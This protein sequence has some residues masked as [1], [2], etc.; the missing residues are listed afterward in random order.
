MKVLSWNIRG[1]LKETAWDH[2]TILLKEHNPDLILLVETHLN[3]EN[4]LLCIN[5]FGHNWSGLFVAAE[6]RSGGIVFVWKKLYYE[7][8]LLFSCDQLMNILIQPLNK[9]PW[10]L[11]GIYASNIPKERSILWKF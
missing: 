4:S 1:G 10:L 5:K 6:G 3:E 9:Q 11:S 2:L 8:K 7:A